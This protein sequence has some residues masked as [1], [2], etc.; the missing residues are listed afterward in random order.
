M[1][2]VPGATGA[3]VAGRV[4]TVLR[5]L[6]VGGRIMLV[7]GVVTAGYE[8]YTATPEQRPRTAVG[9]AGGFAGGFALGA[10]AGLLCGPGAPV[11]SIVAGLVLGAVG[12]IG[13]RAIAEGVYDELNNPRPYAGYPGHSI[14]CPF[15]HDNPATRAAAARLRAPF[16]TAEGDRLF[17]LFRE[18]QGT[19]TPG[20]LTPA[21]LAAIRS[22][23][24]AA[25]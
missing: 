7:V 17:Q 12:A 15:C 22:W 19:G 4:P 21:E 25:R 3:A 23:L 10:G 20:R 6:K 24:P 11:C 2:E 14:V 13:G 9:I 8:L 18:V 16:D 1:A 5:V